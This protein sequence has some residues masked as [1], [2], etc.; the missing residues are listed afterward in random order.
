MWLRL[1]ASVGKVCF[2]I[3][4]TNNETEAEMHAAQTLLMAIK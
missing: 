4:V 2:S 3:L 1:S